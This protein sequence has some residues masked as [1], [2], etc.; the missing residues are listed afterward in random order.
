VPRFNISTLPFGKKRIYVGLYVCV[1]ARV[2]VLCL[3]A[4][5][6]CVCLVSVRGHLLCVCACARVVRACARM[7]MCVCVSACVRWI[8]CVGGCIYV[9]GCVDVCV[10]VPMRV[11]ARVCACACVLCV[12]QC[13]FGRV[14]VWVWAV[15]TCVHACV[16]DMCGSSQQKEHHDSH[17]GSNLFLSDPN[18]A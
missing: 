6:C 1:W 16:C 4:H 12:C 8:A 10:C 2:R 15:G 11:V 14:C 7:C 3:C 17:A 18:T 9:W 13:V 5:M